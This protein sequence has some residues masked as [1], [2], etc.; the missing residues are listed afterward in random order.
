VNRPCGYESGLGKS[1]P[2]NTEAVQK[3]AAATYLT[4]FGPRRGFFTLPNTILHE[5]PRQ[6]AEFL[7]RLQQSLSNQLGWAFRRC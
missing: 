2:E 1:F 3:F 7:N 4:G 6:Q 5:G